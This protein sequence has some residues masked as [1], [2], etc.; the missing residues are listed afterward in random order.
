MCS[1][2]P[3]I[4]FAK[5][6]SLAKEIAA[7]AL[8]RVTGGVQVPALNPDKSDAAVVV[9]SRRSNSREVK[10]RVLDKPPPKQVEKTPLA[11]KHVETLVLSDDDVSIVH[12]RTPAVAAKSPNRKVVFAVIYRIVNNN[13]YSVLAVLL[14]RLQL[15]RR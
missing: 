6:V 8:L 13:M 5:Q 11:P 9:T 15:P 1:G 2:D 7:C 3:P 10:A 4:D 12:S 14:R